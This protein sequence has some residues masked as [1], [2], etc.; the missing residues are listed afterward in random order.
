MLTVLLSKLKQA[1]T[2]LWD[3]TRI[4]EKAEEF[5][6]EVKKKRAA[7]KNGK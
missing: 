7:K 5:V 3:Q 6:K 2:W 4:D 1:W